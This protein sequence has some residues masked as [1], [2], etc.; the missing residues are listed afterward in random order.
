MPAHKKGDAM[1]AVKTEY[2]DFYILATNKDLDNTMLR[3]IA[4]GTGFS[5]TDVGDGKKLTT[6]GPRMEDEAKE[7]QDKLEELSKTHGFV[8]VS[9][10]A[11]NYPKSNNS[12]W[13]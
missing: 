5:I 8:V 3:V 2:P 4:G 10:T 9:L 1:S 12:H 11:G 13:E 6:N 7:L